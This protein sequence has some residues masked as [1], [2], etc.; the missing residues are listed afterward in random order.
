MLR[1]E[2]AAS[3]TDVA[4][5]LHLADLQ[6][7]AKLYGDA[8]WEASVGLDERGVTD[9]KAVAIARQADRAVRMA[10]AAV[11]GRGASPRRQ[12]TP[13]RQRSPSG[14]CGPTISANCCG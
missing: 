2:G 1:V 4:G 13:G 14:S 7:L 5:A 3:I 12:Q 8:H 6:A 9:A 10:E 11:S